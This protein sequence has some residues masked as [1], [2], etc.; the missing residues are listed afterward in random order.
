MKQRNINLIY[1]NFYLRSYSDLQNLIIY[2]QKTKIIDI[3][4]LSKVKIWIFSFFIHKVKKA[5]L[6]TK[7]KIILVFIS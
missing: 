4:F 1:L 3:N 6:S 7:Q 5:F 2:L